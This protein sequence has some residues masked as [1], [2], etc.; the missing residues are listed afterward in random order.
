VTVLALL[1]LAAA[2]SALAPRVLPS[3]GWVYRSPRLG[4]AAWYAVLTAVVGSVVAAL[5]AV[6]LSWSRAW[7]MACAWLAWCVETLR[8]ARR[9]GRCRGDS[10]R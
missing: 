3:A 2:V 10:G 7:A 4:L 5:V 1:G 8:V 9:R 6:A